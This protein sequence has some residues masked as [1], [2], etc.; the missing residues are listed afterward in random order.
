MLNF[1]MR[2]PIL[3]II[4]LILAVILWF[5]VKSKSGGEMALVVPLEFFHTP[6]GLIVTQVN[7]DAVTVRISGALAQLEPAVLT[8]ARARINLTRARSGVNTFD[9]R[10]AD[11]TFPPG[12]TI[13]QIS[14]S[15]IKVELDRIMDKVVPVK[16]MVRGRPAPGCRLTAIIVD[17]PSI[18]LRGQSNQVGSIKEV[19]TEEIDISGARETVTCEVPLQLAGLRLQEGARDRVKVTVMVRRGAGGG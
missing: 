13:T 16:A 2:N 7:T 5:F 4:S 9:V 12:L 18:T 8:K 10:A 14:P 17:P 6:E 15:S 1:I 11:F 19:L 3:K